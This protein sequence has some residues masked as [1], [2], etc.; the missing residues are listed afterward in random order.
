MT[1]LAAPN[2]CVY[3]SGCDLLRL[4]R[5]D[6]VDTG[7][8]LQFFR[9]IAPIRWSP[10]RETTFDLPLRRSISV[11][12]SRMKWRTSF[13]RISK[14][15]TSI[16]LRLPCALAQFA[17]I[18]CACF[19]ALILSPAAPAQ[20]INLSLNIFY[21]NQFN[22]N[23]GGTWALVAK[24]SDFGIAGLDTF[25]TNI[26]SLSPSQED[27]APR[28]TYT[29]GTAGRRRY[30]GDC[31]QLCSAYRSHDGIRRQRKDRILG[32]R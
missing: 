29:N 25:L 17:S 31:C 20:T 16:Y 3:L 8:G 5:T 27:H 15:A 12:C 22:A 4:K 2:E 23:S 9:L 6:V 26:D 10:N 21:N 30:N 24:S 19:L 13:S 18:L 1:A 32:Q 11:G 28:G 7:R 14:T